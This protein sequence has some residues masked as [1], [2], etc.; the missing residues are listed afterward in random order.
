MKETAAQIRASYSPAKAWAEMSGDL[1]AYLV[2][3]PLSIYVTVPLVRTGIPAS[4]VTAT[5]LAIGLSLP[6]VA[7]FSGPCDFVFVAALAFAFFVLDCVDGNLARVR[8]NSGQ[9]GALFDAATDAIFWISLLLAFGVLVQKRNGWLAPYGIGVGLA[10]AVVSLL[11]RRVRDE[12][13]SLY[14]TSASTTDTR[15]LSIGVG[16]W[17]K[18][19]FSGLDQTYPLVLV[20]AGLA[21]ALDAALLGVLIYASV[22]CAASFVLAFKKAARLDRS[23]RGTP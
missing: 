23:S 16:E 4:A 12:F 3:R 19:G 17:I 13:R 5:C 11:G 9:S 20:I 6:F 15:P 21:Q 14:E 10:V 2:Y 18:I 7:A 8:G 1:P 22:I